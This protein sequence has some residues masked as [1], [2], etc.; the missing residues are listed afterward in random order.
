MKF[1]NTGTIIS[2]NTTSGTGNTTSQVNTQSNI[3]VNTQ[4]NDS[5]KNTLQSP[6]NINIFKNNHKM[7]T[8]ANTKNTPKLNFKPLDFAKSPTNAT[9]KLN[10][11]RGTV[12][13][14]DFQVLKQFSKK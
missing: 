2:S 1:V 8:T 6:K 11:M 12:K 10:T 7:L 5:N 4:G 13:S 14:L 9:V 3:Q